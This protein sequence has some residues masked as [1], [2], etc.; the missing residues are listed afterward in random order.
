[1]REPDEIVHKL[2]L[3]SMSGCIFKADR[4]LN[5]YAKGMR[6]AGFIDPDRH[7]IE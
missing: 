2:K 1:M 5:Q 4:S 7:R 6:F 3:G